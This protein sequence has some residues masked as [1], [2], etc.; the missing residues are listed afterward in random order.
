MATRRRWLIAANLGL[1]GAIVVAAF[2]GSAAGLQPASRAR[3]QYTMVAGEIQGGGDA[4]AI[5]VIDSINE[6]M[7]A[8]R[9]N[10]SRGELDG[11]DY[12][13]LHED[14]NKETGR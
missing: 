2:A 5:Y 1:A 11:I 10:Q 12:R 6:E 13:N 14:G 7:V 4:S 8:L 9:W 3:G